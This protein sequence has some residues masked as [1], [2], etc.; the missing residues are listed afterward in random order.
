MVN[1][2]GAVRYGLLVELLIL[3]G[4]V[5]QSDATLRPLLPLFCTLELLGDFLGLLET[6]WRITVTCTPMLESH[7]A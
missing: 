2:V 5:A 1:S 6:T 3:L 7:W 4:V